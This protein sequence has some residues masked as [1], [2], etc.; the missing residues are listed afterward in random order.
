MRTKGVWKPP[1]SDSFAKIYPKTPGFCDGIR[2]RLVSALPNFGLFR[3]S[4]EPFFDAGRQVP[5]QEGYY[6]ICSDAG[7]PLAPGFEMG[8]LNA[9]RLKRVADCRYASKST[10]GCA[11]KFTQGF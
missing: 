8:P 6:L 7:A 10:Q 11:L 2:P 1:I 3:A 4:L 9:F 5:K